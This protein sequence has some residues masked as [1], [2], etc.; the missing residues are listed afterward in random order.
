MEIGE[1]TIVLVVG[2]LAALIVFLVWRVQHQL[3]KHA[4]ALLSLI[5]DPTRQ[6][7][8]AYEH[9]LRA[10]TDK[11]VRSLRAR[12]QP[13]GTKGEK[14]DEPDGHPDRNLGYVPPPP[15]PFLVPPGV[16]LPALRMTSDD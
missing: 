13:T 12:A 14:K 4:D 1:A 3:D 2:V 7:G 15:E 5:P 16:G 10:E 11:A 9:K 8:S 6:S